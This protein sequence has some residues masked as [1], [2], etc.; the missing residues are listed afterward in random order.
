L[1][2]AVMVG[3]A[4][5]VMHRWEEQDRVIATL[6]ERAAAATD[7]GSVRRLNAT[8][9]VLRGIAM[10][11]R[12]DSNG[13]RD[14]LTRHLNLTGNVG[15][16]VRQELG[17]IEAEANRPAEAI[18]H[19]STTLDGYMRPLALYGIAT[20]YEKLNQPDSAQTYWA[21]IVKLTE[22][23]DALPRIVEARNALARATKER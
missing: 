22:K 16:M 7:T 4:L 10:H 18:R 21:H 15:L 23:G 3:T 8:A 2:C 19:F 17:W 12:G 1:T 20:M 13:A 9:E 6:R 14:L 5:A 11:R